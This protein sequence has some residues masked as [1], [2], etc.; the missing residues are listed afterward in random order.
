MKNTKENQRSDGN[1]PEV[2]AILSK[3]PDF[4]ATQSDTL[5]VKMLIEEFPEVDIEEE[6]RKYLFWVI[7]QPRDQNKQQKWN[8]RATIP[9]TMIAR[10]LKQYHAQS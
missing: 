3:L 9:A 10:F 4:K 1:V 6:S 8:Y 2:V 5:I 7:D